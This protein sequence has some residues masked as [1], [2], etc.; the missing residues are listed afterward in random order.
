MDHIFQCHRQIVDLMKRLM[1][2]LTIAV[3]IPHVSTSQSCCPNGISFWSQ[4]GIDNFQ[5]NY[6]G[7]TEIEG[8]VFIVNNYSPKIT[9]L[10]GLNV[11]TSIGEGL[12]LDGMDA[13]KSFSGLENLEYIGGSLEI[14]GIDSLT[15]ITAL[16][17]LEAIGGWLWV[18]RNQLL[19][20]L[21]GLDNITHIGGDLSIYGNDKLKN[22]S[23][24]SNV[25]SIN[26]EVNIFNNPSLASLTGLENVTSIGGYMFVVYNDSLCSL[27]GL[28]NIDAASI[29]GLQ[30]YGNDCLSECDVLSICN[31]LESPNGTPWIFD[32]S[33]GCNSVPEV[34]EECEW[35]G[36]NEITT[37]PI[38]SIH[39]NPFTTSTTI[40]YEM[41]EPSHVQLSIYNTIGEIVCRAEDRFMAVGKYSYIWSGDWL[42]E[43]LYFVVLNNEE[44]VRM[45]KMMKR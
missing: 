18:D 25:T 2:F 26:G 12:V 45:V 43:G 16:S 17:K 19:T 35:V 22:V 32:N 28:D 21:S 29:Q 8:N 42:P 3:L 38:I 41:T 4:T 40:E 13:L 37:N 11:V 9:N 15:D 23:A 24:L 30:I 39:P 6:P 7:C 33:E 31:Y 14:M 34:E 44:G 27:T 20:N 5:A 36:V 10:H 1:V